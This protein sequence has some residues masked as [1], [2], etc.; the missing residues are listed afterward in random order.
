MHFQKMIATNYSYGIERNEKAL[1]A[2]NAD[3]TKW[4]NPL[5]VQ[6][7]Y[8]PSMKIYCVYGHGKVP[9]FRFQVRKSELI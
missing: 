2:N 6:L 3:H 1:V 5:E 8:A 7:P 9:L 4:S